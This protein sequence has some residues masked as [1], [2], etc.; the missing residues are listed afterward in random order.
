MKPWTTL[1]LAV[2]L[3][4]L[5]GQGPGHTQQ[6]DVDKIATTIDDFHAA[7]SALDIGKMDDV[8]AHA[9]YVTLI[10]PRD[11]TVTIGWVAVRK[12]FQT[13]VF[14]FWNELKITGRDAPH[15]HINGEV[16]WV[17]SIS[18]ATGKPKSGAAVVNAPTFETGVFEKRG[19]RWVIVSWTAWRVPQ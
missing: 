18:V 8:W 12:A 3:A 4:L 14:G 1:I 19:D 10:H 9:P 13:E 15:I 7:L 11:K 5:T 6:S 16:A 2:G 17:N